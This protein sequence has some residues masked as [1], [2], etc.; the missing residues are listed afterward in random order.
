M[1]HQEFIQ[2]IAPLIQKE[3]KARGYKVCSPMIA[4]ACCE[5]NY[6]AS[7]LSSEYHN[8]FGMKCGS[9]WT[10]ARVDLKTK[11]EYKPGELTEI[12]DAFR[13]YKSME[14]GVK[15]YFDFISTKRY[16]NLKQC[17]TPLAYCQ[18]IKADG[19]ATSSKYVDTLMNFINREKLTVYDNLQNGKKVMRIGHASI[20]ERGKISGGVAGDQTGKEVCIRNYYDKN[21][22]TVLRPV[23]DLIASR[24]AECCEWLCKSPLVGYDQSNRNSLCEQVEQLNWDWTKLNKPVETDCSEFMTVCAECAAKKKMTHLTMAGGKHNGPTTSTMV[25]VFVRSGWYTSQPFVSPS[26]NQ[27]KRGDILVRPGSHTVMVLDDYE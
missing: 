6:G 22:I 8:Y 27:L 7:L 26:H 15:G 1:T 4:Q 10:G 20:D 24:S 3:A 13:V 18:T 16:A 17:S 5:S 2:K 23:S 14:E 21:W 12:K 25:N 11:E 19:Y 9:K